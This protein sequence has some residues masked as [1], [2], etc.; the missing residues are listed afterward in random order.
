VIVEAFPGSGKTT[1]VP[2]ALL[3]HFSGRI[4]V[5]EPRRIAARLAAEWVAGE[6]G[7]K[8]GQTVGY[9]VR[10]EDVSSPVTRLKYITEGILL[11]YMCSS[12]A[13]N[14]VD[15]VVLDE[16]HERHLHTDAA[17]AMVRHLQMTSRPDLRLVIMSATIDAE[18]IRSRLGETKVF[19]LEGRLHPLTVRY[20]PD[21]G[22]RPLKSRVSQA[23]KEMFADERCAGHILVFLPGYGEIRACMEALGEFAERHGALLLELRSETPA[24]GQKKVFTPS[25]KRKIILSTNVAETSVTIS[26]VTGVIDSGLARIAGFAHWSGLPTLDVRPVSQASCTQRAGR[27]GR[28]MPGL[29]TRLYSEYDFQSRPH[30]ERPEIS[31]SDLSE[32][33]LGMTLILEAG[34]GPALQV[35]DLPWLQEPPPSMVESASELLRMLGAF[36]RKGSV[37]SL[38]RRVSSYPLHP[39]LARMVEEGRRIGCEAQSLLAATMVSEGM[40]IKKGAS[41]GE[42]SD[43]DIGLQLELFRELERSP[44]SLE[45]HAS[46]VERATL[47][48]IERAA[49]SLCRQRGI[50][51]QDALLP[52][53]DD[54][55]A[56]V[57]L[58]GFPDRVAQVRSSERRQSGSLPGGSAAELIFC[59][60]G[61]GTLARTSAVT[62]S[63]FIAA[64]MADEKTSGADAAT[65]ISVYAAQS[66]SAELL[67]LAGG[68][69]VREE[70]ACY[71]DEAAG[72]VRNVERLLYGRLV[73]EE[74]S[75]PADS[76]ACEEVL[77]EAL[78]SAWPGPLKSA[79]AMAQYG[80]RVRLLKEIGVDCDFP[81]L[82]GEGFD[83][84]IHHICRGRRSFDEIA[85]SSLEEYIESMQS[86]QA[87]NALKS[88]APL[89]IQIGCNRKA[90]VH[91]EEG[92][93]PWV[94][95]RLQD[96]FGV[97]ETPRIGG[98]KV[99]LV[100]HLC[101]PGGQVVQVT[102]D[103]G[104]FWRNAYPSVKKEMSRRYPKHYWPDDPAK[105]EPRMP[106]RGVNRRQK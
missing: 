93:K 101:G 53:G 68:A 2:P 49:Q 66:V 43:S 70:S 74:R 42:K 72:R 54:D 21:P 23:V 62:D 26:G 32:M 83:S 90:R 67:A 44:R 75:I 19:S 12:P 96:F 9:Q 34:R 80:S 18:Q 84:L 15:C 20:V 79:E 46:A 41:L 40:L 37:T 1:R 76:L 95:S 29:V 87:R 65:A 31:R 8:C 10:F 35:R 88:L 91:Y 14:G 78:R 71:F 102:S 28:E 50:G 69:L 51:W 5:L 38:G 22:G 86:P 13:L 64:V 98:G 57:V 11:R 17:F 85:V 45:R 89:T 100:V 39:R 63:T 4:I 103:L 16:F 58:S 59:L 61:G 33:V 52:I 99:P 94:A 47:R 30:F 97:M 55:L 104:S 27:A 92:K 82:E 105:A 48:R 6:T 106:G 56:A 7:E 77:T 36:D 3:R 25:E 24:D 81:D 73:L 60:G